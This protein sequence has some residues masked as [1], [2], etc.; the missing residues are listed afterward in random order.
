MSR[1]K[2]ATVVFGL[3]GGLATADADGGSAHPHY[4]NG[5]L[6]IPRVDAN[7]QVAKY[8]GVQFV[9]NSTGSWDLVDLRAD[10][11]Y[12]LDGANIL[13]AELI[14]TSSLPRQAL[15]KIKWSEW[16]CHKAYPVH[17]NYTN[18]HFEIRMFRV[19]HPPLTHDCGG[20]VGGDEVI[21]LPIYGFPAGKYTYSVYGRAGGAPFTGQFELHA[22][23][24]LLRSP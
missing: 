11:E 8:Q 19:F 23:N 15:M 24:Q 6:I 9:L 7:G 22:D 16:G 12:L 21:P 1:Y 5:N 2:Y 3:C 14:L 10:G 17:Q 13:S 4:D 20:M 18:G